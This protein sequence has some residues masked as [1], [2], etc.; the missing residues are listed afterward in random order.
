MRRLTLILSDLYLPP[1][2][3]APLPSIPRLENL[4]WLLRF[5]RPSQSLLSWRTEICG[6]AGR[7]ELSRFPPAEV[8]ARGTVAEP[9]AAT[10]WLAVPVHY[11]ARLDHVRL[12]P[13]GLPRL[14][15]E[16]RAA[17]CSDFRRAFGPE[18]ALHDAGTRGFL[19][20]GLA[21]LHAQ[22]RDPAQL[23]GAD[24]APGLPRGP[25]ASTLRRLGAEI[26]MWMHGSPRNRE[27][28]QRRLPA[29]SSL[30]LW[31]GDPAPPS[32]PGS[33]DTPGSIAI[34]GED[35][36]LAGF[37]RHATGK[38]LLPV[39]EALDH[40]VPTTDYRVIELAPMTNPAHA[41]ARLDSLWFGPARVALTQGAL[42]R[43]D[44]LANER[45]FH[46]TRQDRLAFWRRRRPWFEAIGRAVGAKA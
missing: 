7:P 2:V 45:G 35:S 21:P 25:D 38:D 20:T 37:S 44:I 26:E 33:S 8:A 11:E 19:L 28:E 13:A 5:A 9:L 23:L 31:G 24:I 14:S 39:P 18:L 10:S 12:T 27:R 46:V 41:L 43:I 34:A 3:D 42:D 17:W 36:F 40:F 30:W 15:S 32:R 4:E 22:T 16:E 1:E 6:Y 29:I